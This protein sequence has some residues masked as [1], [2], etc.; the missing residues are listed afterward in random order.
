MYRVYQV[1]KYLSYN[2]LVNN[3]IIPDL[4]LEIEETV[5][6]K[7]DHPS[8]V[9]NTK[10]FMFF[11]ML[12][13]Y[14][15]RGGLRLFLPNQDISLGTDPIYSHIVD[16]INDMKNISTYE[17]SED[18]IDVIKS[19]LYLTSL[20]YDDHPYTDEDI[21]GKRIFKKDSS[22]ES[23]DKSF[24]KISEAYSETI[25]DVIFK[26][27]Y[28]WYKYRKYLSG[29][30]LF[31][32][33]YSYK[34]KIVGHPDIVTDMCVLD[35]K[36]TKSLA[37]MG[38]LATLQVLT[39]YSLIKESFDKTSEEFSSFKYVGFLLP[40]QKDIIIFDL[41]DW[42]Y[43]NYLNVL[44]EICSYRV[45]RHIV[46]NKS[47]YET[48]LKRVSTTPWQ[49]F[50]RDPITGKAKVVSSNIRRIYNLINDNDMQMFV[51]A[52]YV[53]NLCD[54]K[55]YQ[56]LYLRNDL[57]VA[58]SIGGKGVVVH[59]GC[60]K[61]IP[62]D[63]ALN[64]MEDEV[65]EALKY[66][67][68]DCPLLLE[69]PCGKGSEVCTEIEDFMKFFDRFNNEECDKLGVCIDTAHVHSAGY[70]PMEYIKDWNEYDIAIKLVHFNDS[71]M[72]K[73]SCVD[74][75]ASPGE[76]YIGSKKMNQIGLWC[77]NRNIP[78]VYE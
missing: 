70:D 10:S 50:L 65:R 46:I 37:N 61:K 32:A 7:G 8:F 73:G 75:H 52:P 64:N 34:K 38:K 21:F 60:R 67:T 59:T 5:F 12:Y 62:E 71:E 63:I 1:I 35:I 23:F 19:S 51:H 78:L 57:I 6:L 2:R 47:I 24:L 66:A 16:I 44:T 20:L 15:I 3:N 69:T 9:Y 28:K 30:V 29:K 55:E 74:K 13:D 25:I 18:I 43:H 39:Y 22:N 4:L 72:E 26:I 11:G 40:L 31:N 68:E 42:D 17:T 53:I 58:S 54:M 41:G 77:H 76:G 48:L 36:T 27:I 56:R 33:E 14:I 49:I 45:G